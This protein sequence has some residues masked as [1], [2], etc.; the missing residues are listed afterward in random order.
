MA[1]VQSPKSPL[2]PKLK[3][4][5]FFGF[6][7]AP[8][9]QRVSFALAEKGLKRAKQVPWQSDTIKVLRLTECGYP[10]ARN[11][12]ALAA[13]YRRIETRPGFQEGV[14]ARNRLFHNVFRLKAR[15]EHLL[16][17]GIQREVVSPF[18]VLS[19]SLCKSWR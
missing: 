13:W 1:L 4:V 15:V 11:F 18:E 7:G 12:P 8:C 2:I 9:S 19:P 17:V 6:D 3:G 10:F 16:G 5:H 14:L